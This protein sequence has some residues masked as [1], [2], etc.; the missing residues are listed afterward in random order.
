MHPD[1]KNGLTSLTSITYGGQ[2]VSILPESVF[3]VQ[4]YSL[5]YEQVVIALLERI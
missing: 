3:D 2:D 4:I 5:G 1:K